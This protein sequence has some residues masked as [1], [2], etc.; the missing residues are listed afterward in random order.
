MTRIT[1]IGV[2]LAKKVFQIHGVDAEGKIIVARKLRRKEVLTFFS[3]TRP[4]GSPGPSWFTAA[5]TRPAIAPP[6]IEPRRAWRPDKRLGNGDGRCDLGR[7]IA[8]PER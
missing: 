6:N 4:R 5:S 1:T 2:D 3:P 8:T 7:M